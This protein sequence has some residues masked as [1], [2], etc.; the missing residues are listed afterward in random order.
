M[1]NQVT[2]YRRLACLFAAG[3][4]FLTIGAL[5]QKPAETQ[6]LPRIEILDALNDKALVQ[7]LRGGGYVLYMRHA[8]TGIVTAECT[9]SNLTPKGESQARK[10]GEGIRNLALPIGEV[11]A[12]EYCRARDTARLLDAGDVKVTEDLNLA[13]GRAGY[14]LATERYRRLGKVPRAGTNTVLVSHLFTIGPQDRW[15]VPDIAEMIVFRPDGKGAT[16]PVARVPVAK[17]EELARIVAA[18]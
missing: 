11:W 12:S 1:P 2:G 7:A 17:W 3:N 9:Q 13:G 15:I 4:F 14:D 8:E 18:N 5:A 10:A 16:V 6:A